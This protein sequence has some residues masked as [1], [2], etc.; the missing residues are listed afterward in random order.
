MNSKNKRSLL[1]AALHIDSI[2]F[3]IHCI[4][5]S[6]HSFQL[7]QIVSP[8]SVLSTSGY[9]AL[10]WLPLRHYLRPSIVADTLCGPKCRLSDNSI[11]PLTGHPAPGRESISPPQVTKV[12]N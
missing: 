10:L 5:Y 6:H 3:S 9:F 8:S 12:D 11:C 7:D 2:S 1:E 4:P